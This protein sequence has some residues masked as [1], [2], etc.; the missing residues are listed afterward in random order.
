MNRR[1]AIK[2]AGA[3]VVS[4][5]LAGRAESASAAGPGR[6]RAGGDFT[7][8]FR[9]PSMLYFDLAD[10]GTKA[11]LHFTDFPYDPV[12]PLATHVPEI[13]ISSSGTTCRGFGSKKRLRLAGLHLTP[14]MLDTFAPK[15]YKAVTAPTSTAADKPTETSAGVFDWS[16]L[17][18]TP[19]LPVAVDTTA[20]SDATLTGISLESGA[21][22]ADQPHDPDARKALWIW[23]NLAEWAK[24]EVS[25][26]DALQ[27][28]AT[29][30]L[31]LKGRYE[32]GKAVIKVGSL[33][34]PKTTFDLE[35]A[36]ANDGDAIDVLISAEPPS[37]NHAIQA[38][39]H[40]LYCSY[41]NVA[42]TEVALPDRVLPYL[43]PL[44]F[45]NKVQALGMI[46][47][48]YQPTP[49]PLCGTMR[50]IQ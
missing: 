48:G 22:T 12:C 27:S 28:A 42:A 25:L 44:D 36:P 49:R 35:F 13:S 5:M 33:L 31:K 43:S 9:G 47:G 41:Y 19:K 37:L 26:K 2:T 11:F 39:P 20:L 50:V 17:K 7:I 23:A 16:S 34:D 10:A 8:T 38:R 29:D 21:L 18:W 32:N 46:H 30:V 3:T 24:A 14:M 4:S 15:D 1:E 6:T 45:D 40:M